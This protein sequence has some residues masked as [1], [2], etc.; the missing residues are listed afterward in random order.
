[1]AVFVG[2]PLLLWT[3]LASLF[4]AVGAVAVVAWIAAALLFERAV[5]R[6]RWLV[7]GLRPELGKRIAAVASP[8]ATMRASDHIARELAGDLDPLAAAAPLVSADELRVLGR[9]RLVDLK[10]RG[11]GDPPAGGEA[12]FAWWQREIVA[13][14]EKTLR[15]RGVDPAA[16]LAQPP[17]E[18]PDVVAWCP[19]CLAQYRGGGA[20]ARVCANQGCAD[21]VLRVFDQPGGSATPATNSPA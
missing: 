8:L 7:R 13:R 21:I 14:V 20:A 3:P 5:R 10:F 17:A 1:V 18:G 16:L 19:C 9:A 11:G 6:S 12:D 15:A 4:L 2:L